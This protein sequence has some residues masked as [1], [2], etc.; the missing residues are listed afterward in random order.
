DYITHRGGEVWVGTLIQIA[1]QFGLSGQAVRSSLSRM[2]HNGWLRVRRVGNRSF[3]SLTPKS[4]RLIDEGTRR[5]FVRRTGAWDG[6]W[7]LLS[8][9]IPERRRA[10]RDD[11]R[12]QLA[13]MGFGPLASGTWISPHGLETEVSA[14][15]ERLGVRDLVEL[16]VAAHVGFA[17]DRALAR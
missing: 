16:F 8:Y 6:R 4:K 15:V 5:I 10:V 9:S 13:W 7:R 3:Y 2:S 14:L 17:D 1:A 11:L 12:K